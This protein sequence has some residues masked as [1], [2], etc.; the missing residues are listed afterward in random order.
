MSEFALLEALVAVGLPE[1]LQDAVA[2]AVGDAASIPLADVK[3]LL[4]GAGV[5][6]AAAKRV[7]GRLVRCQGQC[8]AV[9]VQPRSVL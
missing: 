6:L 9:A 3:D 2:G 4:V 8:G 1:A 7:V 5:G